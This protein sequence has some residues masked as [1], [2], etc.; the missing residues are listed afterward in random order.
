MITRNLFRQAALA[1]RHN[2][3]LWL[4]GL[5]SS[6]AKLFGNIVRIGLVF[7]LP[8]WMG[9][10]DWSASQLS[11]LLSR[12]ESWVAIRNWLMGALIL[13]AVALL[14]LW[15]ISTIAEGGLI[16]AITLGK[17]G[18]Q[19]NTR[20]ALAQGYQHLAQFV[21]VDTI[22][23]FPAFAI[24]LLLILITTAVVIS[25]MLSGISGS[26]SSAEGS[27]AAAVACLIPM[28]VLL[29]PVYL[30]TKLF[31][32]V[33]FRKLVLADIGVR[34]SIRGAWRLIRE[35]PASIIV[36]AA[37]LWGTGYLFSGT[38]SLVELPLFGIIFLPLIPMEIGAVNFLAEASRWFTLLHAVVLLVSSG[39]TALLHAFT[40]AAWTILM[41]PEEWPES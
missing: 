13:A 35:R 34:E 26:A 10:T 25:I 12:Q 28:L 39:L 29:L 6:S 27:L 8:V 31:R 23:Y 16:A 24:L 15:I 19:L 41:L 21:T 37:V 30:L 33:A 22:L 2:K 7:A 11:S 1:V 32:R 20:A 40:S 9:S 4:L 5:L 38:L 14:L 3:T 17:N 18:Q 36:V